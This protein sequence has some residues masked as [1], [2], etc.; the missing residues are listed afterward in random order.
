MKYYLFLFFLGFGFS[1]VVLAQKLPLNLTIE[2]VWSL[3][4][5]E[6][7]AG[8][9]VGGLS[10]CVK[11]DDRI[12]F[13]S[14]DRGG[15]G[16]ARVISYIWDVSKNEIDLKSGK[17]FK[18]ENQD[19][20]KIL[21][22][23]GIAIN[24]QGEFLFSNE[25][26]LNK[27]PR[28]APEIFWANAQG[29]RLREVKMDPEFLPNPTGPQTQGVQNNLAF[30]GL[31]SDLALHKWGA[32]LEGPLL[33]GSGQTS[34]TQTGSVDQPALR[35]HLIYVESA[36][37]SLKFD[38]KYKYPLPEMEGTFSLMMGVTDFLMYSDNE[39]LVLER[40]AEFSLQGLL[41]NVQLC[42]ASKQEPDRLDRKCF[43]NL[44]KDTALLKKIAVATNGKMQTMGNF[45][46][47]CWL[48]EK[49]TQFMV[50]SD[51]NF[52]KTE[53]TLFLLYNLH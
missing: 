29:K 31:S 25:G 14:D 49:K 45:E 18:I 43:Y 51:N 41:M 40:G 21:D 53:N 47:L 1:K 48:N 39:L 17:I 24:S 12:Y 6:K 46:G 28:Q 4:P 37:N 35:D 42:R 27:K 19:K 36:L 8:L 7:I 9:K 26:D 23:E 38:K 5:S 52:N 2:K 16:G 32:F 34:D 15:E 10:G 50:V 22:L 3:L 30:E 13:I 44:N 33:A 20:K 11:R